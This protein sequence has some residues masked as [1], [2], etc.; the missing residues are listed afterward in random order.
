MTNSGGGYTGAPVVTI[1]D[2]S[3]SVAITALVAVTSPA[4]SSALSSRECSNGPDRHSPNSG[5]NTSSITNNLDFR[6]PIATTACR[7]RSCLASS[8]NLP[9]DMAAHFFGYHPDVEPRNHVPPYLPAAG[10]EHAGSC[11]SKTRTRKRPWRKNI[12]PSSRSS[13]WPTSWCPR[14]DP[15]PRKPVPAEQDVPDVNRRLMSRTRDQRQNRRGQ[16][17]QASA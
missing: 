16:S 12:L 17:D 9:L 13:R 3:G 2:G 8:E 4:A 11:A 6:S 15:D 7:S 1:T 14:R 10:L 5:S